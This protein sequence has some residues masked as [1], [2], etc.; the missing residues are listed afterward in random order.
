MRRP[1][2]ARG[3]AGVVALLALGAALDGCRQR[4]DVGAP[5]CP[6]VAVLA[7]ASHMAVYRD[8]PG[9]ELTDIRY[10]AD[11]ARISGECV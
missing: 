1:L 9:R 6:R 3:A 2:I 5:P 4:D 7:D 10:E 11:L 8:G